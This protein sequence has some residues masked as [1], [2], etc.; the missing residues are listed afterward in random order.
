M[1]T[2]TTILFILFFGSFANAQDCS[3]VK[4]GKFKSAITMPDS[5]KYIT[6]L[7]RMQNI[8]TEESNTGVK[9]QFKVTWTSDC[10]YELSNPKVLKGKMEGVRNDQVLYVKITKVTATSYMAE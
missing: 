3:K 1:R 8:Q 4:I 2:I 10:S 5:K 7:H 6:I 9:M